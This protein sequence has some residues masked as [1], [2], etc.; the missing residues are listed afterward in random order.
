MNLRKVMAGLL[1][2][3]AFAACKE[4]EHFMTLSEKKFSISDDGGDLYVDLSANVYYRVVNDNDF[5]TISPVSN[6]GPVTTYCLS[7]EPNREDNSR[8]ARIKFIG[9][10][11][12]PLALDITQSKFVPYGVSVTELEVAFNATSAEFEV[13]GEKAWT[14]TCDNP[15]FTLSRD[16][17]EGSAVVT[18]SF[19]ENETED[20]VSAVVSV[21]IKDE[22]FNVTIT[23]S[24]AM[25]SGVSP[26][27]LEIGYNQTSA[28]FSI[29]S[30][31]SWT[32]SCDNPV[33]TLSATSG[34]GDS[35]ISISCPQNE[36]EDAIYGKV[37]VNIGDLTFYVNIVQTANPG[38]AYVD[39]SRNG[40]SNSYIVSKAGNYKFKAD[41]RGNGVVPESAAALI[42]AAINPDHVGVLWCTYNSLTAPQSVEAMVRNIKLVDGYIKFSSASE[43]TP[44]NA[45]IAA[46]DASNAIIWS[47]HIWFTDEPATSEIGG[48]YWMDRNLGATCAN[49][50]GDIKSC[51]LYYQW[52]RKDPMRAPA[53]WDGTFSATTPELG[54]SEQEIPVSEINGTIAASIANPRQFINTYPGGA[55]PK[56]WIYNTEH[57]DRWMDSKKTMFDPCPAGYKVP[58]DA[59]LVSFV[60]AAGLPGGSVKYSKDE[61]AKAAYKPDDHVLETS[62]WSLPLCGIISYNDGTNIADCGSTARYVSSTCSTSPSAYYCNINASAFNF[63]NSA[64][65]GHASAVRC[66]KE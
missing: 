31:K 42:Q 44:G 21:R 22:V 56:D 50:K 39:L 37:T 53:S 41:I 9:D 16:S 59:Q 61:N 35:V 8:T 14:A 46:Y 13:L 57:V 48:A 66:V 18:V 6:E 23:Q 49:I 58:S 5:V 32:A 64:T 47:W 3:A 62:L 4:E 38:M 1:A 19:P 43:L 51:G 12:T 17:G 2:L 60:E 36:G 45:V 54:E 10:Y 55:G 27:N 34:S 24:G 65:R 11:V 63:A 33:F 26:E 30:T 20:P 28:Q 52:G 40:C 7:V 25:L 15:A 29:F